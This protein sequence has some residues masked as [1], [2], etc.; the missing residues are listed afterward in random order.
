MPLHFHSSVVLYT[1][2]VV[3]CLLESGLRSCLHRCVCGNLFNNLTA[4]ICRWRTKQDLVQSHAHIHRGLLSL[5]VHTV[6]QCWINGGGKFP[7]FPLPR[8]LTLSSSCPCRLDSSSC[9]VCRD[10]KN[11]DGPELSLHNS[12]CCRTGSAAAD[13]ARPAAALMSEK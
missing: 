4:G 6:C 10:R 11:G 9:P 8:P 3:A 7:N 5:L 1:L 13:T 12:C 2:P